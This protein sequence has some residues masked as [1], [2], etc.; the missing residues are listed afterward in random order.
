MKVA[1]RRAQSVLLDKTKCYMRRAISVK[2][3]ESIGPAQMYNMTPSQNSRYCGPHGRFVLCLSNLTRT[4]TREASYTR[5][6]NSSVTSSV[7]PARSEP[8]PPNPSAISLA[9]AVPKYKALCTGT[10]GSSSSKASIH[11]LQNI[12]SY[13]QNILFRF[14]HHGYKQIF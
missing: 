4:A 11:H 12:N 10:T 5:P 1:G 3:K 8:K 6:P 2:K 13:Y 14:N 7:L 9:M